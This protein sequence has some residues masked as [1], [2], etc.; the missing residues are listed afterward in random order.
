MALAA[1]TTQ[2]SVDNFNRLKLSGGYEVQLPDFPEDPD[3][4]KV[5]QQL[6]ETEKLTFYK[7]RQ[8]ILRYFSYGLTKKGVGSYIRWTK[9]KI[10]T[11]V[12]KG[13]YFLKKTLSHASTVTDPKALPPDLTEETEDVKDEVILSLDKYPENITEKEKAYVEQSLSALVTNMWGN[14]ANISKGNGIGMSFVG[15]LIFNTNIG[16]KGFLWGRSLSTDIGVN[17]HTGEGYIKFYYDRES[18]KKAG[19]ALDIG[20]LMNSMVHF[21]NSDLEKGDLIEAT[22]TKLPPV[23]SYRRSDQ[24]N[25]WGAQFGVHAGDMVGMVLASAGIPQG[26]MLIPVMRYLGFMTV[27]KSS[28]KRRSLGQIKLKRGHPLLKFMGYSEIIDAGG[29]EKAGMSPRDTEI[30][31]THTFECKGFLL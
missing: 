23:G 28:L 29:L 3:Q 20:I 27:Y 15:G 4:L 24:Y 19:F 17:F 26:L 10:V 5:F 8:M 9:T 6:S 18:L 11:G 31:T 12:E 1:T 30:E 25:G 7:N 2:A 13:R 22:H 14:I 21:T 16:N